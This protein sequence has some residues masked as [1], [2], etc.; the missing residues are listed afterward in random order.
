MTAEPD[1][2]PGIEVAVAPIPDHASG[3]PVVMARFTTEADAIEVHVKGGKAVVYLT[4]D[5]RQAEA[6]AQ[7]VAGGLLQGAQ[8]A[9][10]AKPQIVT[11]G[12]PG[13]VVPGGL[14][15]ANPH[16]VLRDR[17]GRRS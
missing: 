12:T 6:F 16:E 4:V 5:A 1:P 8:V 17:N 3:I 15:G 2:L 7:I 11:P 14:N 13:F 10:A 9:L